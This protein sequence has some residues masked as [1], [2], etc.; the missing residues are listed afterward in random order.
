[1][2]VRCFVTAAEE[3]K[4]CRVRCSTGTELC[5]DSSIFRVLSLG[6]FQKDRTAETWDWKRASQGRRHW[7]SG[8]CSA[9][10][11]HLSVP[12]RGSCVW[13]W[14]LITD[15]LGTNLGT[16]CE[17]T[18]SQDTGVQ[19]EADQTLICAATGMQWETGEQWVHMGG[20]R[21]GFPEEVS[22]KESW[23]SYS[24]RRGRESSCVSG[25][26]EKRQVWNPE[27]EWR[28]CGQKQQRM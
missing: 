11:Q 12:G 24:R 17:S 5:S 4:V 18:P 15:S 13:S 3:S 2:W 7:D 19:E 8:R 26:W 14:M 16:Y 6:Y 1:M 10:S 27:I 23:E 9:M 25:S 20:T 28:R 21:R 22:W